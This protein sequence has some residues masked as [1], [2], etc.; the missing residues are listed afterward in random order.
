MMSKV[1]FWTINPDGSKT[2]DCEREIS[3]QEQDAFIHYLDDHY[4]KMR[5]DDLR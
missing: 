2:L 1:K 4:P 3:Q 5:K